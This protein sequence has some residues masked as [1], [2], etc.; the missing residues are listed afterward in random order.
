M[1]WNEMHAIDFESPQGQK[2][3][4]TKVVRYP[5][6]VEPY[7]QNTQALHMSKFCLLEGA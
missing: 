1:E 2:A 7:F 4:G 3:Y 6:N 5:L